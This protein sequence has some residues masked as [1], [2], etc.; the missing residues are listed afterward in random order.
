MKRFLRRH[1][2]LLAM[3]GLV[4]L[5]ALANGRT[6]ERLG[7]GLQ[8]A[9]PLAGFGCAVA[10]GG[11]GRYALRFLL[12]EAGIHIPKAAL[13]EVEVNR[14]P[15]DG[16]GGFPSGHTAAASFGA[17]GLLRSCLAQSPAAQGVAVLA[18]GV[19]GGSRIVAG[20]H[21]IWQVLAGVIWGW[22]AQILGLGALDRGA[23][24]LARALRRRL[25][26]NGGAG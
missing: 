2:A 3:L 8:I 16:R 13:G 6:P 20:K 10:G 19:T 24:R 7:D 5:V 12:L 15:D 9:L 17:A 14:R 11:T 18:V 26:G 25:S 1:L 4:G 22:L 23:A 21:T